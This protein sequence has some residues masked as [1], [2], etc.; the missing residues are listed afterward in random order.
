MNNKTTFLIGIIG[1]SLFVVSSVLG[2]FLIVIYCFQIKILHLFLV[3][4]KRL[5]D[6]K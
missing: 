5:N 6:E 2:G 3:K 1:V 4:I